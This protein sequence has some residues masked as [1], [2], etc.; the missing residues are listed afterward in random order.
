MIFHVVLKAY[1]AE[2]IPERHSGIFLAGIQIFSAS[3]TP[4]KNL[5]G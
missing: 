4:A 2:K 1:R 3:W 5:P